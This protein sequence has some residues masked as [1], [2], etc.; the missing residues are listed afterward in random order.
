MGPRDALAWQKP[1][2]HQA[3]SVIFGKVNVIQDTGFAAFQRR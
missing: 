2:F 3:L 1:E